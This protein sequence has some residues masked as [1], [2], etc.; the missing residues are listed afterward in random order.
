LALARRIGERMFDG[1]VLG[2]ITRM[3]R[4]RKVMG[5]QYQKGN[6]EREMFAAELYGVG[7]VEIESQYS[8]RETSRREVDGLR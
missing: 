1:A 8:C 6:R 3:G 4:G 2:R 5:D 7:V